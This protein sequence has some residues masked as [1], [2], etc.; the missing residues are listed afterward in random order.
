MLCYYLEPIALGDREMAIELSGKEEGIHEARH[1]H[2]DTYG[3]I[4]VVAAQ[5]VQLEYNDDRHEGNPSDRVV[6]EK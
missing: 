1:G 4:S 6:E 3:C 5:L 2:Y